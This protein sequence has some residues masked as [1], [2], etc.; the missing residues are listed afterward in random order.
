[1]TDYNVNIVIDQETNYEAPAWFNSTFQSRQ[2]PNDQVHFI[3]TRVVGHG[4]HFFELVGHNGKRF[5]GKVSDCQSNRKEDRQKSFEELC[6]EAT[7]LK[8]LTDAKYDY[9]PR[10]CLFSRIYGIEPIILMELMGPD[11]GKLIDNPEVLKMSNQSIAVATRDMLSALNGMHELG[12]C[13]QDVKLEN[14]CVVRAEDNSIVRVKLVDFGMTVGFKWT[15]LRECDFQLEEVKSNSEICGT[16]PYIPRAGYVDTLAAPLDDLES[17]FYQLMRMFGQQVKWFKK[18]Y[19]ESYGQKVDFW[20]KRSRTYR[21]DLLHS[22]FVL[23]RDSRRS[24]R[25]SYELLILQLKQTIH[26]FD[27]RSSNEILMIKK[28]K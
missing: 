28:L 4:A 15:E 11:L 6:K 18:R 16:L 9:S 3:A 12:F 8:L 19:H 20:A 27:N 22:W 17:L 14:F 24:S 2:L 10:F 13:V 1:M 23:I 25:D 21:I 5:A 7:F 26:G